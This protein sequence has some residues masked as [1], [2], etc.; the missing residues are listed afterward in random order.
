MTVIA[1]DGQ[2][3]AADTQSTCGDNISR[4]RKIKKLRGHLV[5]ITGDLSFGMEMMDWFSKGADPALWR[6]DWRAPDKGASLFVIRP[7]KT[8]W[9]YESSPYPFQFQRR[10]AAA[11]SGAYLAMVAMDCG[12]NAVDAVLLAGRYSV[13]CGEEVFRLSFDSPDEDLPISH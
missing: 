11:G 10:I 9:K 3:L 6:H 7:D 1:W 12:K 8:A 2:D 13:S 4:V 5:G